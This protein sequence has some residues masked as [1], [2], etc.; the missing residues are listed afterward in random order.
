MSGSGVGEIGF[1]SV[2]ASTP[3]SRGYHVS[4]HGS[5]SVH[6]FIGVVVDDFESC[7]LGGFVMPTSSTKSGENVYVTC[8][9]N[10]VIRNPRLGAKQAT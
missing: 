4:D 9:R 6:L 1:A 8:N 2:G 3:P 7:P 5:Q 10:T